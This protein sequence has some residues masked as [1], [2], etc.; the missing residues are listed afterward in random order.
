MDLEEIFSPES[1][2]EHKK[3]FN[4]PNVIKQANKIVDAVKTTKELTIDEN[5]ASIMLSVMM[6][7]QL[8]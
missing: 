7:N 5:I 8:S 1:I 4:T 2:N 3:Y 6:L